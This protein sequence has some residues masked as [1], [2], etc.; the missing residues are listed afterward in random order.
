[1]DVFS[2]LHA[3]KLDEAGPYAARLERLGFAAAAVEETQHDPFMPLLMAAGQ[4]KNL[5]LGTG[6][7]VAFARSPMILATQAWDLQ[8]HSKGRFELGLG[9]QVKAHIERRFGMPWTPPTARMRDY[10]LALRAIWGCWQNRTELKFA[11]EN[12]TLD[13]MLPRF[14][15]GPIPNPA[16]PIYLAALSAASS[17]LAGEVADGIVL[18]PLNS[19]KYVTEVMLPAVR[20]GAHSAGRRLDGFQ[21]LSTNFVV[22]G[23]SEA[24][25]QPV[26]RRVRQQ[27]A[28]YAAFPTYRTVFETHGWGDAAEKLAAMSHG[29]Q[30]GQAGGKVWEDMGELITDEMVHELAIIATY[31]DLVKRIKERLGG[32]ATRIGLT[33]PFKTPHDEDA[34]RAIVEGLKRG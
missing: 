1:M 23:R 34:A 28:F 8:R 16:I 6:I 5:R 27:I 2:F 3:G 22:T 29:A 24:E 14:N 25:L 32:I 20:E 30:E 19:R 31:D 9:T 11:S 15:P 17:R 12:Y 7:A 21:V 4:T 10:V 18:H 33:L 26:I 13:I